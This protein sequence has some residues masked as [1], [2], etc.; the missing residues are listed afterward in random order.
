M[1]ASTP[2][3]TKEAC[4]FRYWHSRSNDGLFYSQS[5]VGFWS[6]LELMISNGTCRDEYSVFKDAGAVV[7]GISGMFF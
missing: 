2:G 3:C 5:T 4:K 1:Q 6:V 7:L